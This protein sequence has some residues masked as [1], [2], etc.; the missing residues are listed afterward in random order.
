[1]SQNISGTEKTV[2]ACED[3]YFFAPVFAASNLEKGTMTHRLSHKELFATDM[4]AVLMIT[5]LS[6]PKS[7]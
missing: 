6:F 7:L 2:A 5:M 3:V 1:M 4:L